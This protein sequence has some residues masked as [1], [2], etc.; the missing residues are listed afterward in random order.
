MTPLDI[1]LIP[2]G[3]AG[4]VYP[5]VGLGK[6]LSARGHRVR[7]ATG[8]YFEQVVRQAGLEFCELGTEEEFL[9]AL[10]NPDLWHPRRGFR[11]V[12]E[13]MLIPGMERVYEMLTHVVGERSPVVVC[14]LTC[15]G[16]RI[17]RETLGIRVVT[18]H[19][20]PAVFRSQYEAPYLPPLVMGPGVPAWLKRWQFWLVDVAMID[21][22]LRGPLNEFRSRLGLAPVRR[23]F[24]RWVH[25]PD[26]VIAMFPEWYAAHQPDWP[27]G[28]RLTGFPLWDE[29]EVP[30]TPDLEE[31]LAGG[32]PPI[33]FT[34]GS[35]NVY[36][37]E[38]FREAADACKQLGRRALFCTKFPEQLPAELPATVKHVAFAPFSTLLPRTAALCHHG[39]IGT[40]SQAIAAGVPQLIMPLS[41][42]QP[43]N[44]AR[45]RRLQ[46][47]DYLW[48][49]QFRSAQVAAQLGR[50][51]SSE[52]VAAQCR[53]WQQAVQAH[54]GLEGAAVAVEEIA[55]Q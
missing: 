46:L 26:G 41:H 53:R 50:L 32:S 5:F 29:P 11:T 3:S 31:F 23:V 45:V 38:F 30:L 15:F 14:P 22:Y 18:V 27:P 12:C 37:S 10:R 7:V 48:P 34:P 28:T 43:D 54:N 55:R 44:A 1:L 21:R 16:A 51:I 25:S 9:E 52:Q 19:L 42:D 20:Q 33:V 6:Q 36:G 13:K 24:D 47:G 17:A 39:G 49:K 2:L 35:A 40:T 4:D 8:A